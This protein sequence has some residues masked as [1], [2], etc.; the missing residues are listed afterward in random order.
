MLSFNNK[1]NRKKFARS[2]FSVHRTRLDLL[3]MYARMVAIT[4]LVA[5]DIAIDICQLLK[6]EF[7]YLVAKRDQINIET[8]I[9]VVRFIGELVKFGLYSKLEALMCLKILLYNFQHHQIEMTCAFLEVCGYYLYN[10]KESRLRINALLEKMMRLKTAHSLDSRHSVQIENCYYLIKPPTSNCT[11][12][13]KKTHMQRYIR[14]IFFEQLNKHNVENTIRLL[15]RFNYDDPIV[16]DEIV[17]C[18]TK[19]YKVSYNLI[20][21]LAD[22]LSGLYF[23]QQ[24]VVLRVID[25]VF[26]DIRICLE[27][28]STK[29]SQRRIAMVTYLGEIY[30]YQL[31]EANDIIHTLYM[32]ISLGVSMSYENLSEFDPPQ[33]MFRLKMA[34]VLLNICGAYFT[35]HAHK[36]RYVSIL[37]AFMKKY[38]KK[39]D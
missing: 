26:E 6:N 24:N 15:R 35:K 12:L 39:L 29:Q 8:K 2:L 33:S 31:I 27:S 10:N 17:K 25:N 11:L 20:K 9:K 3:P 1:P 37:N 14:Y 19:A 21:Q 4:N 28:S 32:I 16:F 34:C 30:N 36:K 13:K 38:T 22:V 18:L 5:P 23:Y 7:K